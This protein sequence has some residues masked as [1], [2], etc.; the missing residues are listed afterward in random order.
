MAKR[1]RFLIIAVLM[2]ILEVAVVICCGWPVWAECSGDIWSLEHLVFLAALG[3]TSLA[4][5]WTQVVPAQGTLLSVRS[6]GRGRTAAPN[7][8]QARGQAD[9]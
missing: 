8:V 1:A 3:A 4:N 6:A 2:T 9:V 7:P 5:I